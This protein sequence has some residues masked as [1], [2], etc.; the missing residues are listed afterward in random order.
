M[1]DFLKKKSKN[2]SD[3]FEKPNKWDLFLEL[4]SEEQESYV[5]MTFTAFRFLP[6]SQKSKQIQKIVDK[7]ELLPDEQSIDVCSKINSVLE[8]F[9]PDLRNKLTDDPGLKPLLE[10]LQ[11]VK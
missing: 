7:L 8:Q 11:S 10:K 4:S 5:K 3:S 2:D 9:S 1:L 6:G